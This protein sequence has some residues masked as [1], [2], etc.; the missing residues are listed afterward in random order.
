M[1]VLEYSCI[2]MLGPLLASNF[3]HTTHW[4]SHYIP[5]NSIYIY[6]SYLVE[7][8]K[9]E[10]NI[11]SI[12][13]TFNVY[14]AYKYIYIYSIVVTFTLSLIQM[15]PSHMNGE[16]SLR[17]CCCRWMLTGRWLEANKGIGVCRCRRSLDLRYPFIYHIIRIH[18]CAV[19]EMAFW[20]G[21]A[22]ALLWYSMY[23][24]Y[25][26]RCASCWHNFFLSPRPSCCVAC[27]ATSRKI[28]Y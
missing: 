28:Y 20:I 22:R 25:M 17:Y 4:C 12:G 15:P 5:L 13:I 23:Y 24:Y 2:L 18:G 11:I 6:I 1:I 10:K 27:V 19:Y 3:R 7:R 26:S 14:I 9:N 16:H 8:E 21:T